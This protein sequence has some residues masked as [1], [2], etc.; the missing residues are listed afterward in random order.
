MTHYAV[1]IE[2]TTRQESLRDPVSALEDLIEALADY[3]PSAGF[4][5]RGWLSVRLT[6]PASSV[7]QAANTARAIAAEAIA[8][9]DAAAT[10]VR[11]EAMTEAELDA[12][13]GFVHVPDLVG[14]PEAAELLGVS[15]QRVRQMVD[16]GKFTTAR[17]IGERAWVLARHEVETKVR[18]RS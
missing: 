5:P 3:S 12:R 1:N 15:A 10:I 7:E 13:E 2:Y 11:I 8:A 16:E 14:L 9:V 18:A 6:F 17:R 4:S